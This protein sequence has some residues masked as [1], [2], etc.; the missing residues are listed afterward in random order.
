VTTQAEAVEIL[1]R[2]HR[3]VLALLAGIPDGDLEVPSTIGGGNW[4]A[5]DLLGHITTWEETALATTD[6]WR[7]GERPSIEDTFLADGVDGFNAAAVSRK[8]ADPLDG[9]RRRFDEV[10]AELAA[11]IRAT[12]DEEWAAPAFWP[13]AQPMSFGETLGGILGAPD[14]PFDHVS[15]HEADLRDFAEARR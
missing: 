12:T 3:D 13:G 4:S 7:R 6:G 2:G 10:H 15:A 8:A 11:S 14:G 9:I 5:K 1:A